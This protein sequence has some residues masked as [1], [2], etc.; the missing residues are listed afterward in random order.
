MDVGAEDVVVG[1]TIHEHAEETLDASPPQLETKVGRA[2]V[3]DEAVYVGQNA[4]TLADCWINWRRQLSWLH[5]DTVVGM[6]AADVG[7]VTASFL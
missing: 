4:E 3:A 5:F 7:V 6:A 2:A 1:V